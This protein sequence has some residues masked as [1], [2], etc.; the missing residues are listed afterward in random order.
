M[1]LDHRQVIIP[2][3]Q[4]SALC[5]SRID[6]PVQ[7]H[8]YFFVCPFTNQNHEIE[9]SLSLRSGR[10]ARNLL[11]IGSV[12]EAWSTTARLANHRLT[13]EDHMFLCPALHHAVE[14]LHC[15]FSQFVHGLY[16]GCKWWCGVSR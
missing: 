2:P 1:V 9:N 6:R 15:S 12:T 10:I 4:G 13:G 8:D 5:R 3:I 16:H 14:D 7:T 11:E